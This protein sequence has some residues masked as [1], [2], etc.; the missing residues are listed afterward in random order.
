MDAAVFSGG[1][2]IVVSDVVVVL[3]ELLILP[4]SSSFEACAVVVAVGT[5]ASRLS[6]SWRTCTRTKDFEGAGSS[7][8]RASL[9]G[10]D[11]EPGLWRAQLSGWPGFLRVAEPVHPK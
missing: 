11:P 5:L 9:R 2:V 3:V 10:Q 6:S 4:L 7:A 1:G 8:S